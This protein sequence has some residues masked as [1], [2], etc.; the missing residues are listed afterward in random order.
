MLIE[1]SGQKDAVEA[2][3]AQQVYATRK[4]DDRV[5]KF[6]TLEELPQPGTAEVNGAW[7]EQTESQIEK[8][9]SEARKAWDKANPDAQEGSGPYPY[10]TTVTLRRRGAAVPQ[11]LVVKFADGSSETVQWND[12]TNWQRYSW[13]KP[14][15]AVYAELDPQRLHFLDASKIDDSRTIKSDR[16][17]SQR[18]GS[19]LAALFQILFSLIA[20]V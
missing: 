1:S 17:A 14:A 4:V 19:Q 2:V 18:W 10:R 7:V 8:R 16:S 5:E 3:F 12:D 11:T 13:V 15:K 6:T 20:T 9:I